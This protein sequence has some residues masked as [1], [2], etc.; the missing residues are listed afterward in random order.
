MIF[1]STV[2]LFLFLPIV[3]TGYYLIPTTRL[4]NIALLVASLFFYAWGEGFYVLLMLFSIALNYTTGVI[5][6]RCD[7][8]RQKRILLTLAIFLNLSM[9]GAF[10]YANFLAD[11]INLLL[12][13][14]HL[15]QLLIEPVH[16][17]IGISFFTFQAISYII[18][19]YRNE[20]HPQ[21]NPLDCG[22]YIALFPQLIAGPIVRYHDIAQQLGKRA[23]TLVRFNSGAALFIIGLS[24]KM[25]IA[26]PMGAMADQIFALPPSEL[27]IILAWS[28]AFAYCLQ[29]YF[30]FS[31]YSDMAIGLGR[32]FGFELLINFNYPYIAQSFREFWQR[33]HISLSRWFRDYLYIPLGGNKLGRRRTG[34]NLFIVFLLCGF[35]HGASWNFIVWGLLHGCFLVGE[36]GRFGTLLANT[37]RPVRHF[38]LLTALMITWVFFRADDLETSLSF[39]KA[40]TGFAPTFSTLHPLGLFWTKQTVLISIL[41]ILAS[42]PII[43]WIKDRLREPLH[44]RRHIQIGLH[45]GQMSTYML[46]LGLCAMELAAGTHN[47]FIYFRF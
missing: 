2:F 19:I 1:S 45:L 18:D 14:L 15:P 9:L 32:M 5:L 44:N 31:G 8:K 11:N 28:G 10:K 40:M 38:Y 41:G 26:N 29:I 27:T 42:G 16:L 21:R 23:H 6:S 46:L 4:R 24:K 33:W 25:L 7:Q 35:W 3:V 17:P 43:P 36:R 34:I 12:G 13:M 47:P 20:A 37:W 39:I 22:L 30:D